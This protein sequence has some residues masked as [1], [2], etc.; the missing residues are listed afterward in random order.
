M[1]LTYARVVAAVDRKLPRSD[2]AVLVGVRLAT[3]KRWMNHRRTRG[4]LLPNSAPGRPATL[5][6]AQHAALWAQLEAPPAA[7]LTTHG[8]LWEQ[9]Q[10]VR[11][12]TRALARAI[13]SLGW[14]RKQRRW[15]PPSAMSSSPPRTA[16]G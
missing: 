3:M 13:Q 9:T 5:R 10:P 6:P 12:S 15:V 11:V 14:P 7:P 2:V 1:L 4:T 16:S 8:E